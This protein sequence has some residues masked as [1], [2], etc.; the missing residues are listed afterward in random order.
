MATVREYFDTDVKTGSL[1]TTWQL[2]LFDGT[3]VIDVVAK[4]AVDFNAD[5]KYW[6]FFVPR[7]VEAEACIRALLNAPETR[8]CKLGADGDG[9]VMRFCGA[10]DTQMHASTGLVFTG[11]VNIYIDAELGPQAVEDLKSFAATRGLHLV[12]RDAQ[13]ARRRSE[14]EKPLAFLSH[15]TRDKDS[16][17]RE[18]ASE[19]SSLMCPVWYDE[20]SLK[21]G[22]SLRASIEKGLREARRCV[23]VL[24]P[25]FL[26]NGGWGK[27]E[28]DS[29]FT[30]EILEQK[31]LVLPVWHNVSVREVYEYSPRLADK[32]G[33]PSSLGVPEL[34]RRLAREIK[35]DG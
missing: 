33:L 21:V 19:L 23:V 4:I 24:S 20:Y 9:A 31:G 32:V 2:D 34:A 15:D 28:F 6:C 7:V 18:L 14:L 25:A 30:R 29:I 26:S 27:A 35:A 22:D 13:F 3:P 1:H 10:G 5:A 12:V 17:V 8:E 11:R 16:L